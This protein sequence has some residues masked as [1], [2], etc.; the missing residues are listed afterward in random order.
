MRLGFVGLGNQGLPMA[1]RLLDAGHQLTVWA[2][3]PSS[4]TT[5]HD[6]SA[7]VVSTRGDLGRLAEL[8]AVCVFDEVGVNEVVLGPSGV[9]QA[10]SPGN[11][12]VVHS[13]V[14]P[15]AIMDLA[16]RLEPLGLHVVDAPVSGGAQAARRG[17]LTVMLGGDAPVLDRVAPVVESYASNVVRL[18]GLG[19]GQRAKILN[20]A[21]VA[22]NL[23]LATGALDLGE[24]WDLDRDALLSTL[25]S[26]TGGSRALDLIAG[27][28]TLRAM[29]S[30]S[31]R[32]IFAKDIELATEVFG[33]GPEGGVVD[34]ARH[35]FRA[36][37]REAGNPSAA[38]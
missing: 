10:M 2:R 5:F 15:S 14:P 31:A 24:L 19:A 38:D 20:N 35:W 28:G 29:A 11:I 17:D 37:E 30:G 23:H 9:A 8:V 27:G 7:S 26:S 21:L 34:I 36:I 13:T 1:H 18:G 3:R 16:R 12:V 32:E 33:P 4:L 25:S 22:A 6:T